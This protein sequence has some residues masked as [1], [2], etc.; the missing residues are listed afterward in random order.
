[1]GRPHRN[2][3]PGAIHHVIARCNNGEPWALEERD[4]RVLR[5]LLFK[6]AQEFEWLGLAYCLMSN[7][8]HLLLQTPGTLSGGMHRLN[9][10]FAGWFNH[11]YER[12]GH[13]FQDRFIAIRVTDPR[14]LSR[15]FRYI[16]RNPVA[17]GLAEDP[18]D[19]EWS[20]ARAV[21]GRESPPPWI[22]WTLV[23]GAVGG[24]EN[25]LPFLYG[26]DDD[27]VALRELEHIETRPPLS[28]LGIDI[29]DSESIGRARYL[30]RYSVEDIAAFLDVSTR[31]VYRR[32]SDRAAVLRG[33]PA[34]TEG[35]EWE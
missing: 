14:H 5:H 16:L 2:D 24:P 3:E 34:P 32:L 18:A 28:S 33:Q 29:R 13:V 19:W 27:R 30:H 8:Y 12:V 1:M 6:T 15:A 35:D 4:H 7:H 26:G 20:S 10:S 22:D 9:R 17:A 31:T 23:T 25:I 21:V 11:T